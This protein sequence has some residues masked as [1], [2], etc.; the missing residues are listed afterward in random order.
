MKIKAYINYKAQGQNENDSRWAIE[1]VFIVGIIGE[2]EKY[3][4]SRKD[5]DGYMR[6]S[7]SPRA[8]TID[9]NLAYLE[10]VPAKDVFI[11]DEDFIPYGVVWEEPPKNRA[12]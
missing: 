6:P 12:Y 11:I 3:I 10:V 8:F 7:S 4:I 9:S 2:G 5:K 1:E